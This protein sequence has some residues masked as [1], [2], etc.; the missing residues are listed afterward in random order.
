MG[1]EFNPLMEVDRTLPHAE[2]DGTDIDPRIGRY[3]EQYSI[4][5]SP[6]IHAD[7][8]T[9]YVANTVFNTPVAFAINAAPS[10]TA[11]YFLNFK[12]NDI[13]G[14]ADAVRHSIHY[15]RLVMTVIPATATA[16]HFFIK[17][18]NINRFTS[19]GSLLTPSN[20]NTDT[21]PASQA[22]INVGALT[23]AVAGQ[24]SRSICRGV[25]RSAIPVVNDE[26]VFTFGT[27]D[28]N[29]PNATLGGTVAQR[30]VIPCPPLIIGPQ[31]N[32]GLQLWFPGNATTPA[33]FEAEIGFW[34]R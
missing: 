15:I 11:G 24:S 27:A 4:P 26:Y 13:L 9:Y 17:T 32:F 3:R 6:Q 34:E 19:G 22:A 30:L 2:S 18:D 33:S 29:A 16:G 8:G 20:P 14:A 10:E 23:T 1:L 12:N 31:S 5:L 7:E 28:M 25:L 21:S